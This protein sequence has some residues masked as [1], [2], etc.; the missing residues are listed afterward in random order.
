MRGA[1][2]RARVSRQIHRDSPVSSTG[3]EAESDVVFVGW[4]ITQGQVRRGEAMR[5]A[6]ERAR[7]CRQVHRDA[8]TTRPQGRRARGGHDVSSASSTSR[9]A[10]RRIP[11][12]QG[13]VPP[14]RDVRNEHVYS[15]C[16]Q[17][18]TK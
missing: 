13:D 11:V 2:E 9:P 8:A 4:W 16:R 5:G 7:V 14:H 1:D 3:A 12:R 6:D 18:Y 10:L 17:N 15:P